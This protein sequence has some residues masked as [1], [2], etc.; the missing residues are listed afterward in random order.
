[1]FQRASRT[2]NV[3]RVPSPLLFVELTRTYTFDQPQTELRSGESGVK[4]CDP[5][6]RME[7]GRLSGRGVEAMTWSF[8]HARPPLLFRAV[9]LMR[10]GARSNVTVQVYST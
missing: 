8:D 2:K 5:V 4:A 7:L 10:N 6:C 9:S 1:M 3:I